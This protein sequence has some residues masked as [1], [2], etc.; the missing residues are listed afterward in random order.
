MRKIHAKTLIAF[1]IF[2]LFGTN[3][4]LQSSVKDPIIT[5]ACINL[6][7]GKNLDKVIEILTQDLENRPWNHDSRLYLGI[8]YFMKGDMELASKQ[9]ERIEIPTAARGKSFMRASGHIYDTCPENVQN[10]KD[11]RDNRLANAALSNENLGLF[12]F[13]YGLLLKLQD[14]SKEAEKRFKAAIKAGYEEADARFQLFDLN[15]STKN[16]KAAHRELKSLSKLNTEEEEILL[17][18]GY[19]HYQNKMINEAKSCFEKALTSKP[20]CILAKKNLAIIEYNNGN[21]KEAIEIL[22]DIT[23]SHPSDKEAHIRLGRA[24]FHNGEIEKAKE[25]FKAA[26]LAIE[27]ER[28]SPDKLPLLCLDLSNN[29]EFKLNYGN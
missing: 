18:K 9:L 19:L 14:K 5:Y 7:Q 4:A 15:L 2:L 12:H 17:L 21:Y 25:E 27:V 26:E 23:K 1:L 29:I 3:I 10:I 6:K 22:Q 11:Q 13:S 24:Y 20:D 16:Y 8:A 28:Y